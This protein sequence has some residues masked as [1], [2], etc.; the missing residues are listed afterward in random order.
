[1]SAREQAAAM[2]ERVT[3]RLVAFLRRELPGAQG[4]VAVVLVPLPEGTFQAITVKAIAPEI[5]GR[6]DVPALL[7]RMAEDLERGRP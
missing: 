3:Q 7:R 2:V 6:A 1:M 4:I 5:E